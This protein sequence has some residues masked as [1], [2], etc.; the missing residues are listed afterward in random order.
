MR[1]QKLF[2]FISV[3]L[4]ISCSSPNQISA[5]P[6]KQSPALSIQPNQLIVQTQSPTELA[7][8][9]KLYQG[10]VLDQIMV[11]D[12]TWTLLQ[13]NPQTYEAENLTALQQHLP[14]PPV[15]LAATT[16]E[17]TWLTAAHIL[18]YRPE[19]VQS[20]DVN[21]LGR[22]PSA[23]IP[24][25]DSSFQLGG[26]LEGWWLRKT[27]VQEAWQYSIGTGVKV[28]YLDTGF[29][30]NH[31]EIKRR[32]ILHGENNQLTGLKPE[33]RGNIEEPS[34]EHGMV[35]MLIGFAE[36]DNHMPSVGVAPNAEV[37]PYV[38]TNM[39]EASQ[40]ILSAVKHQA[41]VIGLNLAWEMYPYG[42]RLTEFGSYFVLRNVI[43]HTITSYGIP[44]I[45]AAH[46]YAEPIRGGPREWF[47]ANLTGQPSLYR[48]NTPLALIVSGGIQ[49]NGQ[50]AL[51]TWLNP[52]LLPGMNGR[53]SNYGED[54]IWAPAT[55]LDIASPD[56]TVLQSQQV[57]GTSAACPFVTGVVALIKAKAPALS[58]SRIYELLRQTGNPVN[59]QNLMGSTAKPVPLVNVQK[60]VEAVIE[61]DLKG[62]L[63]DY[64]Y[65]DLG[66]GQ[67]VARPDGQWEWLNDN[68]HKRLMPTHP[69]LVQ[70]PNP[71]ANQQVRVWGWQGPT[72]EVFKIEGVNP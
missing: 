26:P 11:E 68:Q 36:R 32:M 15:G 50:Q 30:Q 31:P 44:I 69:L 22:L 18:K 70:S 10:T 21:V 64:V 53:G 48:K 54:L 27:N 34:G 49:I 23:P 33:Q 63:S 25:N 40:G 20:L 51:S 9:A 67:L 5:P 56:H 7:V 72:I 37:M 8:L 38:V 14:Q 58:P 65:Q 16:M 19:L 52:H 13:I 43:D 12:K 29:K 55:F 60:V 41:Q 6:T 45:T 39:W 47:P 17:P 71:L 62:Q 66:T 2:G 57:N 3:T 46:N 24:V 28:A 42:K 61:Q 59:A 4:T 1:L 35:T